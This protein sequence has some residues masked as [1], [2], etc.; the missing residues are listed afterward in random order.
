VYG[1]VGVGLVTGTTGVSGRS[2]VLFPL[3]GPQPYK[4]FITYSGTISSPRRKAKRGFRG[5][6]WFFSVA[7]NIFLVTLI[8]PVGIDGQF[9]KISQ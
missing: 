2:A 7:E 1:F 4:A 3:S 8:D 5:F 9:K 6:L